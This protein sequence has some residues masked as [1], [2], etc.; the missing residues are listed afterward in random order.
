MKLFANIESM[1]DEIDQMEKDEKPRRNDRAVVSAF[2]RGQPPL[3]QKEADAMGLRVNVN[4]LFGYTD[5]ATAK[6][7]MVALYT[8]PPRLW[9]VALDYAPVVNKNSWEQKVTSALNRAIKKGSKLRMPYEGVA[10]DATFHG[11]G[12]FFFKN[13]YTPFPNQLPLSKRLI[14]TGSPAD[15]NELTH[16]AIPTELTIHDVMFHIRRESKGWNVGNLKTLSKACFDTLN[17]KNDWSSRAL[18]A[19]DSNNPEELEYARQ[20]R[21]DIDRVWRTSI[22]VYYFFQ[23][24]PSRDG[25]PLDLTIVAKQIAKEARGEIEKGRRVLFET[26]EHYPTITDAIQPFFMDCILGG[27]P[28]WHRIKGVGHLNYSVSW[29]IEL[30]MSRLMQG[31]GDQATTIWQVSD[32]ANRE[33]LERIILKHNGI[34]PENVNLLPNQREMNFTGVISVLNLFRQAAARNSQ[35]SSA[36][37][38]DQGADELEVQA[39]FRQGQISAQQSSRLANWYDAFSRLGTTCLS[40]FTN[41]EVHP[42]MACYSEVCEFQSELRRQGIPLYYVQPHNVQVTAYKLTGD[43]DEQKALRA[44]SFFMQNLAMFPAE[45]QPILKRIITGAFSGNYELAESV[46][47]IDDTPNIDQVRNAEGENNT[48]ILQGRAPDIAAIDID[49]D[50]VDVHF[51]GLTSILSE[52]VQ[53]NQETFTPKGLASFKA[54]GG[55][56][57]M[58]INRIDSM[59]K[60]EL[61]RKLMDTM[62]GF[63]KMGEKLAHNMEQKQAA[64]PDP[65]VDPIE[66]A[67]LELD[68]RKVEL[69]QSKH[70]FAQSKFNRIQASKDHSGSLDE[71]LK[72]AQDARNEEKHRSDL[73]ARDVELSLAVRDSG[74]NGAG[75]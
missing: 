44:A 13:P 24:D 70:D 66:A 29:H 37:T 14:P 7:Q 20:E 23:A 43:G 67:R 47:P 1:I 48:C 33:E 57:I 19:V 4:N 50:H 17:S 12:E 49:E 71:S 18:S 58:H 46:I 55:H 52:H 51:K 6:E 8:K 32:T 15:P 59:G 22:P 65:N 3:T 72:L 73:A 21:A 35:A 34:V 2:F 75:G 56:T 64:E 40:R 16:F 11:E 36:N 74:R 25:R 39:V 9:N 38:G 63:A 27:A 5:L 28:K 68:S 10:G 26:E 60:K 42:D 30:L 45:S 41:P 53:M 31:A 61:A 54:L 62:N 69:A